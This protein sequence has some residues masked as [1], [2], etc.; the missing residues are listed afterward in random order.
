MIVTII[1]FTLSWLIHLDL[2]LI[3][4]LVENFNPE[5]FNENISKAIQSL[6]F[7]EENLHTS[8][9]NFK[10]AFLEISNKHAPFLVF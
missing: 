5:A 3:F 7:D 10:H 1:W 4:L 8:W 9:E 2:N 6:N